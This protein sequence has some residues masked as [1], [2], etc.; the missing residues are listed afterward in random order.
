MTG[1]IFCTSIVDTCLSCVDLSVVATD[2]FS[3]LGLD[4]FRVVAFHGNGDATVSNWVW[5][6][7]SWLYRPILEY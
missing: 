4:F 5:V 7:E 1:S 6:E 3:E 2:V